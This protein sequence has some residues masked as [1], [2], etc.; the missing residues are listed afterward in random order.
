MI[1]SV[2]AVTARLHKCNGVINHSSTFFS[3]NRCNEDKLHSLDFH[4]LLSAGYNMILYMLI[5]LIVHYNGKWHPYHTW[6]N[7]R[8]NRRSGQQRR[9][10]TTEEVSVSYAT[11]ERTAVKKGRAEWLGVLLARRT[12]LD[13]SS[14][15]DTVG[16]QQ[17]QSGDT[18]FL[19]MSSTRGL[20]RFRRVRQGQRDVVATQ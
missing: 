19:A 6:L 20:T 9:W 3:R 13:H 8:T 11:G 18:A 14:Q 4:S 17:P 10:D 2:W 1:A 7:T 12:F 15:H 5:V 16:G